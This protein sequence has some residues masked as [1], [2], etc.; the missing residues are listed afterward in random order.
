MIKNAKFVS[1]WDGDTN[2]ITSCKVNMETK[3]VFDIER[4]DKEGLATLNTLDAEYIDID[5][6]IHP[7]SA[8]KAETEY[9]V[10]NI[11]RILCDQ[12]DKGEKSIWDLD[13]DHPSTQ[14]FNRKILAANRMYKWLYE[15]GILKSVSFEFKDYSNIT[16]FA[17]DTAELRPY[18]SQMENSGA[19]DAGLAVHHIFDEKYTPCFYSGA[20][21]I[22]W[23][24]MTYRDTD[25]MVSQSWECGLVKQLQTSDVLEV[26]NIQR[27]KGVK[28][29]V[30]AA[31]E[32]CGFIPEGKNKEE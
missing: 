29:A 3:E 11:P 12:Y 8:N 1:V 22:G 27:Q 16:Y 24:M 15:Q 14:E 30:H 32:I 31:F 7:V 5:G 10:A 13:P 19:L 28:A 2:V 18:R 25:G 21:Q 23:T 6:E 20:F 9:W 26:L 4:A 17:L